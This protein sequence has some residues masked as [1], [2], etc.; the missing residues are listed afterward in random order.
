MQDTKDRKNLFN[1]LFNKRKSP[2]KKSK[3]L[4]EK[5]TKKHEKSLL[6]KSSSQTKLSSSNSMNYSEKFYID[7]KGNQDKINKMFGF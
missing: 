4:K 6:V 3:T 7:G 2:K 5:K 1:N